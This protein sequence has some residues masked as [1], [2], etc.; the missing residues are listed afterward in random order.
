MASIPDSNGNLQTCYRNN[1]GDLRVIDTTTQ[2]CANNETT[3]NLSQAVTNSST[4]YFRVISD[5]VDI[6]A[7]RNIE[8]YEWYDGTGTMSTDTGYCLEVNFTPRTAFSNTWRNS[9]APG[10]DP[11]ADISDRCASNLMY[12]Y[13]L[14]PHKHM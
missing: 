7:L 3:F 11:T 5:N 10:I 14:T 12:F 13:T 2:T 6:A 9:I 4:A 1:S 8:D